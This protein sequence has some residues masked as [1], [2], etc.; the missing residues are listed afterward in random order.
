MSLLESSVLGILAVL[1]TGFVARSIESDIMRMMCIA[2]ILAVFWSLVVIAGK[3]LL[4]WLI[5]DIFG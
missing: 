3:E 2:A 1:L 4:D 5:A